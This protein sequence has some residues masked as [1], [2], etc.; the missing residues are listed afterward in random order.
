MRSSLV[1]WPFIVCI[2]V[3]LASLSACR[4]S[5]EDDGMPLPGP[6]GGEH[7]PAP[8][9]GTQLPG[10]D[11]GMGESVSGWDLIEAIVR[12][13]EVECTCPEEIL[14]SEVMEEECL[15]HALPNEDEQACI[16]ASLEA[17]GDAIAPGI[18][19]AIDVLEKSR[20]CLAGA[21]CGDTAAWEACWSTEDDEIIACPGIDELIDIVDF[22]VE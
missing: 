9:G 16:E 6:D 21:E 3:S 20:A 11:G 18:L 1:L 2:W 17:R 22:C 19:C 13:S 7:V 8:D 5:K 4:G 14:G 10:P 12:V 15:A